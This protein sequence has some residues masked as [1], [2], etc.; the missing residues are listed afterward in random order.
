MTLVDAVITFGY[1]ICAAVG[2]VFGRYG[3]GS[4]HHHSRT[5]VAPLLRQIE[6]YSRELARAKT[7]SVML[8][9]T[10]QTL[11]AKLKEAKQETPKAKG[12]G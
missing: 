6:S 8:G 2:Y 4:S 7:V 3:P 10:V 1:F 12:R 9:R 5:K 11:E